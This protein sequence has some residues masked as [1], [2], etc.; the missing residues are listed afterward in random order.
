MTKVPTV[1]LFD[2][3][4]VVVE[5]AGF[6][7]LNALLPAPMAVEELKTRCTNVTAARALGLR[8]FHVNGLE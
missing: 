7:R 3:G 1:L 6:D 8:A 2:L 4:G 5:N